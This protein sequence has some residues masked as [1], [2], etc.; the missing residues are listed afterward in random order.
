M[1][2]RGVDWV[3]GGFNSRGWESTGFFVSR[4]KWENIDW[5]ICNFGSGDL[6]ISDECDQN[7]GSG[8]RSDVY[9]RQL[10][11]DMERDT[12]YPRGQLSTKC[13]L[14]KSIYKVKLRLYPHQRY[15]WCRDY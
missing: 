14:R 10:M 15:T 8:C 5:A 2:S 7:T 4:L 13:K 6:F 3:I 11:D 9:D 12:V 1:R